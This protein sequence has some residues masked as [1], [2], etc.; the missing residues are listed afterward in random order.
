V[1]AISTADKDRSAHAS[2]RGYC[3]QFDRTILEVLGAGTDTEILVEGLEDVDLL[4]PRGTTAV[5]VK[6]WASKKYSTPRSIH[7]PVELMLDAYSQ[8]KNHG[9]ILH[10]HFGQE[11]YPPET[12]TLDE[13]RACLTRR[14]TKGGV[15]IHRDYEKYSE[16]TLIGFTTRLII[17]SG[18]DFE[19]QNRS[20]KKQ[21]AQ[22]LSASDQDVDDLHYAS[23]LTHIQSLAMNPDINKRKINRSDF[24]ERI[25]TRQA[26]YTRWHVETVGADR[27]AT[28][29]ARR[30]KQLKALA[31]NKNKAVV[32]SIAQD[33]VEAQALAC[34]LAVSEYGP[35]KMYTATPWTLV[36]DGTSDQIH[37]IKLAVLKKG[38]GLNDGYETISFQTSAFGARPVVNRRGGGSIIKLASYTI[39]IISMTSFREFIKEGNAFGVVFAPQGLDDELCRDG[40]SDPPVFYQGLSVE[41]IHKI[42]GGK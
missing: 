18:G 20:T 15:Q 35:G 12:L 8:G 16:E 9:F 40:S 6:Y 23:A 24:L 21:L 34:R 19:S 38:V 33:E 36:V 1:T 31:P 14:T 37:R 11:S 42:I 13:L 2:I 27:Y 3:Y 32:I 4:S 26:L 5:Q 39:R 28:G 41:H 25:S 10:V 30:L 7:E 29:L 17:R 22:H